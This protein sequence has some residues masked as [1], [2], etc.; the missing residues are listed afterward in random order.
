VGGENGIP[1]FTTDN[2]WKLFSDL[3]S[4][5]TVVISVRYWRVKIFRFGKPRN[6]NVNKTTRI[7]NV[8]LGT[9]FQLL[10][11]GAFFSGV[12]I[13]INNETSGT[14]I[15]S[16]DH[17][18]LA[19][20]ECFGSRPIAFEFSLIDTKS[21]AWIYLFHT[22]VSFGRKQNKYNSNTTNE[23]YRIRI[24]KQITRTGSNFLCWR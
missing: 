7:K 20:R 12:Q 10:R 4:P 2:Y 23:Q 18:N 14:W 11:L 8:L 1:A 16:P 24:R 17:S 5:R 22:N 3:S 6:P 19:Y 21:F 9:G 15:H 13:S